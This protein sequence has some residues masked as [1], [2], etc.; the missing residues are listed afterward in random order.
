[1]ETY[2]EQLQTIFQMILAQS[3]FLTP[4]L[5]TI[6]MAGIIFALIICLAGYQV[7]KL[8]AALIGLLVGA[9]AAA[10]AAFHFTNDITITIGAAILGGGI[11]AFIA[12]CIYRLGIFILCASLTL[13]FLRNLWIG[14]PPAIT[15]M[16]A[17]AAVFIGFVAA[18]FK[19]I[20]ITLITSIGGAFA[21][22]KLFSTLKGYPTGMAFTVCFAILAVIGFILQY[23]PW[24]D[25]KQRDQEDKQKIKNEKAR[26][27]A[28]NGGSGFLPFSKKN[29][30]KTVRTKKGKNKTKT[31]VVYR[32]GNEDHLDQ[33]GNDHYNHSKYE[34]H[35][36][37][38]CIKN[39]NEEA[40]YTRE[41]HYEP[42]ETYEQTNSYELSDSDTSD[43]SDFNYAKKTVYTHPMDT[44][45]H[46]KVNLTP[47][48]PD[49]STKILNPEQSA[50]NAID[51]TAP[52][53]PNNESKTTY[54]TKHSSSKSVSS[55]SSDEYDFFSVINECINT[56]ED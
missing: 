29:K 56:K 3:T 54:Q 14:Q 47:T 48:K 5:P 11:L 37:N 28:S 8:C 4:Y 33:N 45:Y 23:Q 6:Q 49:T 1:M 24:K 39:Y 20:G 34:E 17:V 46:T 27:K 32:D 50:A 40:A 12:Y 38:N 21:A 26:R 22:V 52:I 31:K 16:C 9:A 2:I 41:Q 53:S 43:N 42:E 35:T 7:R 19:R 25:R 18:F 55:D 44:M 10:I 15:A 51:K 36:D 13:F 30:T